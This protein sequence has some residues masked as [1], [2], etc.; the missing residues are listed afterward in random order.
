MPFHLTQP[1][2]RAARLAE[3]RRELLGCRVLRELGSTDGCN[4]IRSIYREGRGFDGKAPK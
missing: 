2:C 1:L 4:N 3:R